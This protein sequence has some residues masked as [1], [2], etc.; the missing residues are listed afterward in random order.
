MPVTLLPLK[1]SDKFYQSAESQFLD[2]WKHPDKPEPTVKRIFYVLHQSPDAQLHLH[3]HASYAYVA[4]VTLRRINPFDCD[5]ISRHVGV[6]NVEMLFHGTKRSCQ[7]G[8]SKNKIHPCD[9][10]DCHLCSVL[11]FSYNPHYSKP[12]NWF[13]VG[14]YSSATSSKADNWI[15]ST[16]PDTDYKVMLLNNVVVGRTKM[17]YRKAVGITGPPTGY[18]SISGATKA[19]GGFLNYPETVVF[20]ADA[21]CVNSVI[22]YEN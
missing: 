10:A 12:D 4:F 8:D 20:N 16:H 9:R 7:L 19:Q 13:G 2:A 5:R 15:Q 21:I 14:I 22:V 3:R 11:K 18:D 1:K 6:D 17:K